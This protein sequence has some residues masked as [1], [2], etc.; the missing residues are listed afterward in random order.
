MKK[1][2]NVFLRIMTSGKPLDSRNEANM[3]TMVRYILLNSMIFLGGTLLVLFGLESL[4]SG[5]PIQALFDFSMAGMAFVGFVVL[6]TNAPF[7]VSGL[8]TVVPFMMLCAFLA[9][10]SGV[11]GSG[12]LWAYSFPLL[13]I[14]LLGMK[15]GTILSVFLLVVISAA[16]YVPGVSPIEF[17]PAFAG[18]TV[19]VY[20]LVLVCTMVYEQTKVVK[21]RWVARL[22]RTIEA[23]RDE[24]AAMKDNLKTGLFLLN[25][26]FIIQPQ[27]STAVETIFSETDLSEK[28]FLDIISSSI[29]QK[30]SE[31]LTDYFTMVFNRSYDAQMLEDINPL[32]QLEYMSNVTREEKSLRFSFVPIDREDGNVYILGTVDDQTREVELRR[33][34]DDEENKRQ[35]QMRAMFEVIHVEPRVLNDFILDAEYEFNRINTFL[36]DKTR[37]ST[38]V[39]NEIFQGVHAIKSNAI[40]LGLGSFA[41]NVH[42]LEDEIKTIREHFDI[43]FQEILHI[44]LGLEKLMKLKDGFKEIIGKIMA[45]N[46]S[47]GR[48]RE[49]QVLVQTLERVIEKA[50]MDLGKKASLVV[51]NIDAHA[52]EAGPRRVIKEVLMQLVRNS[53]YHG[54]EKPEVRVAKGKLESGSITLSIEIAKGK[55]VIQLVDDGTGLD[56]PAIYKKAV[57]RAMLSVETRADDKNA[58]L[59]ALFS[60]G[61]ST[62]STADMY[63]GRGIGLN[64]VRERVKECKGSIKLQSDD[65]KGTTFRVYLPLIE[66]HGEHTA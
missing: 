11:Q 62:A 23:E 30:E 58:L 1:T 45:F 42:S 14:F 12:V 33:Q 27:Y 17:H 51:K 53:M 25:K 43:S 46:A 52:M 10:S 65:G 28:N 20:I 36:K 64:L 32:H 59:Q 41:S 44:T 26:D 2:S 60:A 55:I 15:G 35:E 34:L 63:G 54:I 66:V 6:R 24:M 61:F 9:I 57:E 13:S 4:K 39:V 56:F 21:D 19:G 37:T 7:V 29:Q 47:E 50:G 8:L 16:V 31:T 48:L 38:E 5:A 18:R 22:T 40:I 49:E 3:D